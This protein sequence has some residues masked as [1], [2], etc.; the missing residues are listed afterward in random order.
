MTTYNMNL[1]T[2]YVP[3]WGVWEVA[4]ELICNAIDADP[5]NMAIEKNGQNEIRIRTQSVPDIAS[6]F[7]I[8]Q[9]DKSIGGSTIG[10]FGEGA[11]MAALAAT[12]MASREG[13]ILR[14]PTQ[15]ITFDFIETLGTKTLHALVSEADNGDG[16]T[17]EIRLPGVS[18]IYAGK[19]EPNMA[20]GPHPKRQPIR[21]S[22]FI[23]GVFI[24]TIDKASVWDWNLPD[25]ETNRDRAM[26]SEWSTA[27]EIGKWLEN[28][29][30]RSIAKEIIQ[31][32]GVIEADSLEYRTGSFKIKESFLKAFHDLYGPDAIL[33]IGDES[34]QVAAR[35]GYN[36]AVILD[37]NIRHVLGLAGV[38]NTK[39]VTNQTYDL[40][41]VNPEPYKQKIEM[42][43]RI[44]EI[45]KAPHIK[46]Q[47]FEVRNDSLMGYADFQ[48]DMVL[49]LSES[50]FRSG[51]DFE[52][53]RTYCHEL[54]HFLSKS[55][56]ASR[57]FENGLDGIAG[58]LAMHILGGAV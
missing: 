48:N 33:A 51:N 20:A 5:E 22:V 8:G 36:I 13:L 19:I 44:D 21:M 58:S 18:H 34:D 29:I 50:L 40:V 39:D 35:Q 46:V 55:F 53:A 54:A 25:L 52:L 9:G 1:A 7:V 12:R 4:R 16:F 47:I 24:N 41:P 14:T 27:W 10:Q 38:Q 3:S 43:R 49:W 26:V 15:T 28:N 42:L 57:G 17:A 30:T 37:K 32:E 31:H 2:S 45:V 11:K 56:D 23:K 6:L